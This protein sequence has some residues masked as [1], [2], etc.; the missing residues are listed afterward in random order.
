MQKF[1]LSNLDCSSCA[2]KL[3][4]GLSNLP[5]IKNVKVNFSTNTLYI[6]T[7]ENIAAQNNLLS[8]LQ[9]HIQAIEPKVQITK[10]ESQAHVESTFNKQ[11]GIFVAIL[12]SLFIC[13]VIMQYNNLFTFFIANTENAQNLASIYFISLYLL[14]GFPVFKATYK[15]LKNK[16]IFDENFLMLFATIAAICLGEMTEAVAVM[17]FFRM[18]EF[19]ESLALNTSRKSL[20]ALIQIIPHIA[21]R[22][23]PKTPLEAPLS[24]EDI[25][26]ELLEVN[27]I[28]IVKAGEKVPINGLV[29]KG[30]SYLDMRAI[31]GESK[32]ITIKEGDNI[33]AGSINTSNALEV[34]VTAR[35]QDSHIAKIQDMVENATNNKAKTQKLITKFAQIYTPIMFAIAFCVATLPPLLLGSTQELWSEWIYKALV[36]LMISC[37][38]ALVISVPL[39]YFGAI[40][41]ASKRGI[42]F[43]GSNH[44]ETLAEIQNIIFDK[45]GT[46]TKGIFAV[47]NVIP[48]KISEQELV[49]IACYAESLSNHPI[50]HS[51]RQY[52]KDMQLPPYPLQEYQEVSGE[53]IVV[54][55]QEEGLLKKILIGNTRL[56]EKHN[57]AIPMDV[58]SM[59]SSAKEQHTTIIYIAA[60]TSNHLQYLG[61]ICIADS[62]KDEAKECIRSLQNLNINNLAILSGDN[63]ASTSDIANQLQI[64]KF[65]AN[66][67]PAQK[68]EMFSLLKK[69]YQESQKDS[70]KT[71]KTAFVGDGIN[72]AVVLSLADVG[73]SI[74]TQDSQN[75]ISKETADIILTQHTLHN[76]ITA[77]KIAKKTRNITWQNISFALSTKLLLV[78]LGVAGIANMWLAVF[79]DVG[80]ALLALANALRCAR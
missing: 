37:P 57:I 1:Q 47:T 62:L 73:I 46:L 13:G 66:L 33:I 38:C 79:G 41:I 6:Q 64:T 9:E 45:T 28:I 60:S 39:G 72:D 7:E 75:D 36:I 5:F 18:G 25:H 42:L 31:N 32:P 8:L 4:R 76:L 20:N 58:H 23:I 10:K 67:M 59:Q 27:D 11:E 74:A 17:L 55:Y 53:G 61:A 43:K 14:A 80:V 52:A 54:T 63:Y 51:L 21:H 49:R 65:Y 56:M 19:I 48:N 35:F 44:L 50:A 24:L 34:K 16:V 3:E 30:K 12:I 2:Q 77:I 71:S 68:A 29:I 22:K 69:E 15:N 78:I 70:N 26:P 40:G